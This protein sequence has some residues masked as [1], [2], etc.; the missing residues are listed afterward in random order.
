[1]EWQMTEKMKGC[2]NRATLHLILG[3]DSGRVQITKKKE[4]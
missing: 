2:R 3:E 1:M 4:E